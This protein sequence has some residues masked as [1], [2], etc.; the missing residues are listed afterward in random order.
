MYLSSSYFIILHFTF[1]SMI[2]LSYF[3]KSVGF[4]SRLLL[5]LLLLYYYYYYCLHTDVQLFQH[6]LLKRLSSLQYVTFKSLSKTYLCGSVSRIFILLH[7]PIWLLSPTPYR[8][9]Y[10]SFNSLSWYQIVSVLWLCFS[11]IL[12]WLVWVFAFPCEL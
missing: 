12:S 3:L 11:S 2:H 4:V 7:W 8:F 6:H 5:L 9:D 10:R 1:R